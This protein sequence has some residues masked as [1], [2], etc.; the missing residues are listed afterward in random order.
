MKKG[1]KQKLNTCGHAHRTFIVSI[2]L[3]NTVACT[4]SF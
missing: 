3:F 1:K 4:R 2:L